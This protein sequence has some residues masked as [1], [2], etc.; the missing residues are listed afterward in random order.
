MITNALILVDGEVMAEVTGQSLMPIT[1]TEE[2]AQELLLGGGAFENTRMA[3]MDCF[4]QIY[5]TDVDVVF[6]ELEESA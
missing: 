5:G 1:D 3:L 2:E 4:G 6:P